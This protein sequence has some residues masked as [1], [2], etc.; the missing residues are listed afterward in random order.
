MGME[1]VSQVV[2][3]RVMMMV[4]MIFRKMMSSNVVRMRQAMPRW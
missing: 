4:M 2:M 1:P 3:M